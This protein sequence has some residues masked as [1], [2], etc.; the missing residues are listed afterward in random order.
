MPVE[1]VTVWAGEVAAI[2][3]AGAAVAAR[4]AWWAPEMAERLLAVGTDTSWHGC[5]C[6]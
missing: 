6:Y 5:A 3:A 4:A 2:D 1:A